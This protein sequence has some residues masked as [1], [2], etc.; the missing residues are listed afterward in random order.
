M[1]MNDYILGCDVLGA[2]MPAAKGARGA[3]KQS[4]ID[5]GNK[6][7]ATG[8]KI[9]SKKRLAKLSKATIAAGKKIVEKGKSA[10]ADDGGAGGGG[11]AGG[12]ASAETPTIPAAALAIPVIPFGLPP[13]GIARSYTPIPPVAPF[14]GSAGKA[15]AASTLV[16]PPPF[17]GAGKSAA[18]AAFVPA[19]PSA[20]LPSARPVTKKAAAPAP[21]PAPVASK[22]VRTAARVHG[23][24][25]FG[26]LLEPDVVGVQIW[27]P[28]LGRYVNQE[29]VGPPPAHMTFAQKGVALADLNAIDAYAYAADAMVLAVNSVNDLLDKGSPDTDGKGQDTINRAFDVV[30]KADASVE[31]GWFD[32]VQQAQQITSDANDWISQAAPG[33]PGT[34]GTVPDGTVPSAPVYGVAWTPNTGYASGSQV[35][36]QGGLYFA[37]TAGTS[38]TYGPS[39]TAPSIID[40][41]VTW[42]Y[43]GQDP[44]LA[45]QQ[46]ALSSGGGG[47][48]SGGGGDSSSDPF[49][50][51]GGDQGSDP[52]GD[53]GDPGLDAPSDDPNAE[54]A[55]A[56]R[57]DAIPSYGGDMSAVSDEGYGGDTGDGGGFQG[58]GFSQ[59]V[60]SEMPGLP[61]AD[62]SQ[63]DGSGDI[64]S[65]LSTSDTGDGS[66]LAQ[67]DASIDASEN[68]DAAP[69]PASEQV[70]GRDAKPAPSIIVKSELPG[71]SNEAW[72]KFVIAMKTA[73][74]GDVSPS[75]A[76]GAF[77]LKPRRLADLGFMKNLLKKRSAPTKE[78][79]NGRM[80]WVG[81]FIAPMTAKRFLGDPNLQYKAFVGSMKD[82]V[83]KLRSKQIPKPDGGPIDGMRLAGVLAILHRAGPNGLKTFGDPSKRFDDTLKLYTAA[84]EAF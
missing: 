58:G 27:N 51:Q 64:F 53:Q 76:L 47:G 63:D 83:Q 32:L 18:R 81:D 52:F 26:D 70:I 40:G 67:A 79:P 13:G 28:T 14:G 72:T 62:A 74:L 4:T 39:G 10:P 29:M 25:I 42:G 65:D 34:D 1:A 55:A 44:A 71:V 80:I 54:M 30:D 75:N 66:E 20:P 82:Y 84:N 73:E 16:A 41:T 60:E 77:E 17:G 35:T 23:D 57:G 43:A 21:A 7:I 31:P 69:A 3:G 2:A 68:A 48:T 33:T 9:S 49:G 56:E 45:A 61:F 46:A 59:L 19:A 24:D 15:A 78:Y 6:L 37:M 50:D 22:S 38:S 8:N 5:A 36:N 11:S 12:G